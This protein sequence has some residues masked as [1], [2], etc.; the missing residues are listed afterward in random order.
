MNRADMPSIMAR[1]LFS[2]EKESGN[3]IWAAKHNRVVA[4]DVAGY[5]AKDGYIRILVK[6]K[7]YL[8]H[9]IVWIFCNGDIGDFD[10][11]H[12][13]GDRSDNRICNL[14]LATRYENNQN[15]RV[16]K[17]S[18]SG[19]KGVGFDERKQKWIARCCVFGVR[20]YVGAF[21]DKLTAEAAIKEFRERKHKSFTNHGHGA[22]GE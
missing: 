15:R 22:T 9:R 21:S 8:A 3:L 14:R 13:N 1:S 5:K 2:Y 17:N 7:S 19:I 20:V 6:R 18:S 10:V 12:I 4:G 11:D 16:N